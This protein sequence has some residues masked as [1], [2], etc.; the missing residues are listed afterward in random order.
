MQTKHSVKLNSYYNYTLPL[1]VDPDGTT[2]LISLKTPHSSFARIVDQKY[3]II[4]PVTFDL[5]T[6]DYWTY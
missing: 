2:P 5:V 4:E 6:Q 3:L 1:A